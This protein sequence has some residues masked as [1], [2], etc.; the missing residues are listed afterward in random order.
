MN[1]TWATTRQQDTDRRLRRWSG[2]GL[3]LLLPMVVLSI[4]L[5]L[6]GERGSRCLTYG[7]E[8]SP[9]PD[10]L[11][12]GC[13]WTTVATGLAATAWPRARWT[14]ARLATVVVQWTAQVVLAFLILSYA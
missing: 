3:G 2:W 8:C 5:V 9:V 14:G 13:F 12:Y 6:A 4:V 1:T 11:L 10:V 7:E